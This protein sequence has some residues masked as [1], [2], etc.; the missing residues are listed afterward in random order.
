M[1]GWMD[2]WQDGWNEGAH[3]VVTREQLLQELGLLVLHRLD[4]ELVVAGEVEPG[5]AGPGVGQLDQRLVAH[6]VLQRTRS[7][8]DSRINRKKRLLKLPP[9]SDGVSFHTDQIVVWLDAKQLPE[10]AEGQRRVRLQTEIWVVMCWGQ[11]AALTA[12]EE[13]T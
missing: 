3:H 4:D 9:Q 11:V 2:G 10:V 5:A 7:R 13:H 6:R 8:C 12:Q 1:A